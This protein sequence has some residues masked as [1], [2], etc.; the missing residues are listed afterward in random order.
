MNNFILDTKPLFQ[1]GLIKQTTSVT[2]G[3]S[4]NES[5]ISFNESGYTF[6]GVSNISFNGPLLASIE[7]TAP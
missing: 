5:G 3:W 7:D 4:F 6:N 2:S 1:D